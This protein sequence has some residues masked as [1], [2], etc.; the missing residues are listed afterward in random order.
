MNNSSNNEK[1]F[2]FGVEGMTCASCVRIVERSLKKMDGIYFVSIN[3]GTEK[4]YV[5]TDEKISFADIKER[6]DSTGYKAIETVPDSEKISKDF[7]S[8]KIRMWISLAVMIPLTIA[9]FF[10]MS[11]FHVNRFV[12]IEA[13]A[14][15][16][17][18]FLPGRYIF[19]SA[20]IAARHAH[21]NMDTLVALGA[22][23]AWMT[24]ILSIIGIEISSFGSLSV[25]LVTI[26]LAGRYIESRLKHSAS[27][28]IRALLAMRPK[29]AS[30]IVDDVITKIPAES[31]S[32]G[33]VIVV[34]SGE[35]IALDGTIIDGE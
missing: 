25:M 15:L 22:L 12:F 24:S 19:K 28:E 16:I 35:N 18:L 4:G 10:H 20:F 9:M 14:G 32:V 31:V 27:G 8:A 6:I 13:I 11:G 5:I 2:T 26:H 33:S 34:R 29:E 21:A 7:K 23:S 30:I 1:R 17:V 3:L